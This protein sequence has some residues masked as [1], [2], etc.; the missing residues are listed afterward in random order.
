MEKG[1]KTRL[2]TVTPCL[3]VPSERIDALGM[4]LD[5]DPAFFQLAIDRVRDGSFFL[6]DT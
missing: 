6:W 2:T 4:A 5:V 3:W 1:I